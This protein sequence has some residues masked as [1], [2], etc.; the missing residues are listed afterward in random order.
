MLDRKFLLLLIRHFNMDIK[1]VVFR[2]K[3]LKAKVYFKRPPTEK[4]DRVK[5]MLLKVQH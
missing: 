5:T 4:P 2:F 1:I 3:E